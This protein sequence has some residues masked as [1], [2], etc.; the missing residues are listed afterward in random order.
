MFAD[1]YHFPKGPL[2][3]MSPSDKQ[4][5][6]LIAEMRMQELEDLNLSREEILN[7]QTR[8]PGLKLLEDPFFQYIKKNR[9][10]REVVIKPGEEFSPDRVIAIALRQ[11]IGI[12]NSAAIHPK[13]L[14][15]KEELSLTAR[16]R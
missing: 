12:D 6:H 4:K 2:K 14:H 7:P 16:W 3:Y 9:L 8:T 1:G 10:I 13:I 5:V 11:D 15:Q